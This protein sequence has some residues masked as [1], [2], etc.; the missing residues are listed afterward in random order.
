[1]GAADVRVFH[2]VTHAPVRDAATVIVLRDRGGTPAVLMGRRGSGAAFMPDLYVFPGGAVDP[3]DG[4]IDLLRPLPEPCRSRIG[5]RADA[6]AAA[7]IRELAEETGLHLGVPGTWDPPADWASFGALGL[8]PDAG[9]LSFV[10]RA[11]TPPGQTRRFDARFFLLDADALAEGDFS[12]ASGELSDLR[13]VPLSDL[14][15]VAV[16]RITSH[17]LQTVA[18]RLPDLGPPPEVPFFR[19]EGEPRRTWASDGP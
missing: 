7:A 17:V 4:D 10:F 1:M 14:A 2:R 13:W 8:R 19:A 16:P 15:Q 6:I 5:P 9:A 3:G 18:S 12:A 11:I